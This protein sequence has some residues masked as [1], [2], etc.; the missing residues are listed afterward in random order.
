MKR[1]LTDGPSPSR[2]VVEDH[3]EFDLLLREPAASPFGDAADIEQIVD[4]L[5]HLT[6]LPVDDIPRLLDDRIA[7][8]HLPKD[9]HGVA[10]GRERPPQLM[11]QQGHKLF[12]A[13]VRLGQAVGRCAGLVSLHSPS[14]HVERG[15]THASLVLVHQ[16][17]D[18]DMA[19]PQPAAIFPELPGSPPSNGPWSP[20]AEVSSRS[21]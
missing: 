18:M 5:D 7:R 15:Q 9:A 10:D 17:R 6:D 4:E 21:G 12:P 11:R 1:P 20:P 13:A 16:R 2:R 14:D 3:A 8:P 19:P